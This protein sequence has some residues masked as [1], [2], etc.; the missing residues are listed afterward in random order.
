[1]CLNTRPFVDDTVREVV[2]TM[3]NRAKLEDL[4][5]WMWSLRVI[6]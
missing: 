4:D 5:H 2:E 6:A 3:A 1:M